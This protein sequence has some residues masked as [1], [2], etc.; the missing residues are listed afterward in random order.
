M[1]QL[2]SEHLH[3]EQVVNKFYIDNTFSLLRII[4]T[5][6][7]IVVH[8]ATPALKN[9]ESSDNFNWWAGNIYE[10]IF[11]SGIPLFL[12]LTGALL[13]EKANSFEFVRKRIQRV[14][15]PFTFWTLVF[16]LAKN[17]IVEIR[18]IDFVEYLVYGNGFTY[19][20]WYVYLIIFLYI[21]M[22]ILRKVVIK[23]E[24]SISSVFLLILFLSIFIHFIPASSEGLIRFLQKTVYVAYI[25]FGHSLVSKEIPSLLRSSLFGFVLIFLGFF[26]TLFG[27]YYTSS[28]TGEHNE[29]LYDSTSFHLFLKSVGVW[30]IAK[31]FASYIRGRSAIILRSL[32]NLCFGIYLIHPLVIEHILA[33][34]LNINYQ[35][36]NTIVGIGLSSI[37][38]FMIAS[39]IIFI[40][41]K[42]PL[43]NYTY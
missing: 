15:L 7:V 26:I 14:V 22:P 18:L 6:S 19:H 13:L 20:L 39:I 25:V 16:L 40:L 37:L 41:S 30:I 28:I 38:C 4:A 5:L 33:I 32:S 12:M 1:Q 36:F 29:V 43:G 11:R 9:F 24:L 35:T 2:I 31:N 23:M 34:R 21:I 27:T 42:L 17:R 3:D 10:S 8:I